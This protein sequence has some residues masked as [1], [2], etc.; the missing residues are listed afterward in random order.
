MAIRTIWS[1]QSTTIEVIKD[2]QSQSQGFSAKM[3]LFFASSIFDGQELTAALQ[4]AYREAVVF[5]S[6]T[7]GELTSGLMLKGSIVAMLFDSDTI[8]D[9][10]VEVIENIASHNEVPAAFHNFETYYHTSME[11]MDVSTHVGIILVDGLS[12]AEEKLMEKIGDL[13]SVTFIGGS[14]GDDLRFQ[15]TYVYANGKAYTNAAIL[16]VIKPMH[17]FDTIKTQSF[18]ALDR[19]LEATDVDEPNR[20]V[21]EFNH[22][23]ALVAYAEALGTTPEAAKEQFMDHPLGLMF[24]EEPYVRSPQMATGNDMVFFCNI[25]KG[26]KLNVLEN[27]DIIADTRQALMAKQQEIGKISAVVNFHCILRTLELEKKGL[28][29]QYG[30]IFTDIPTIGFSTYGEEYIG[31]VN[32]TSTILLFK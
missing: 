30:E 22:K 25:R 16:A 15:K 17:G 21:H 5:G 3:M 28:T 20:T 11:A 31:H 23:P 19:I 9:V 32:Q 1:A 18:S 7:A 27:Q 6:S 29:K 13:T 14:A 2:L 12:K 10:K 8:A 4:N 26:M 24:G